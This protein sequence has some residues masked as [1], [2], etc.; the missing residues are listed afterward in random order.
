[1]VKY[2]FITYATDDHIMFAEHNK[3]SALNVGKFDEVEIY[4]FN[5]IDENF[6]KKNEYL[7]RYKRLGGYGIW[8]PYIILKKLLEIEDGDII[9]YNDS[10]Y[11]W[12]KDIRVFAN[13]I[14]SDKNIGTYYNKPNDTVVHHEK[15]WSKIDSY[16]LMNV[17]GNKIN[18]IKES[19]QVWSGFILLRKNFETI[20]FISEWLT[21]VQDYRIS[22]DIKSIFSREMSGFKENRHDQTTLSILLKL[23]GIKMHHLDNSYLLDM[24]N[25]IYPSLIPRNLSNIV[26]HN[27]HAHSNNKV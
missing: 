5:N 1:M 21:Y 12:L 6:K 15:T 2:H 8:K 17:H 4:S 23:W 7:F 18:Q 22:S 11:I 13:D 20:R 27:N 26:H 9:C 25:P 10:K 19:P 14:L 3:G 24:R 16:I